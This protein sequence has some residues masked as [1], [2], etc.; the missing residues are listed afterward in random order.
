[1]R[2]PRISVLLPERNPTPTLRP[3]MMTMPFQVN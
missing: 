1:M 2:A 3:V